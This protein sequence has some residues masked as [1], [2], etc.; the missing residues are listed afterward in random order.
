MIDE[1]K[2]LIE[3]YERDIDTLDREALICLI[4][5]LVFYLKKI[6]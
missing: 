5:D 2:R 6:K 1:I 4:D 3:E